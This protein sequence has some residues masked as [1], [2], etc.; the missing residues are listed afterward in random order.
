MPIASS[1]SGGSALAGEGE[2]GERGQDADPLAAEF[3]AIDG[4]LAR[5]EAVITDV[6]S[7]RQRGERQKDPLVYDLDSDEAERRGEWRVVLAET[8]D[9]PPVLRAIV[10]LDAWN[11][12]QVLQHARCLRYPSTGPLGSVLFLVR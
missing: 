12:L 3:A 4:V 6:R 9:L 8:E 1:A 5:S 7:A 10:V 11:A 2:A